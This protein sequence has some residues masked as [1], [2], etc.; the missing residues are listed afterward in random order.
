[1]RRYLPERLEL[2]VLADNSP[3]GDPWYTLGFPQVATCGCLVISEELPSGHHRIG[4]PPAALS[5]APLLPIQGPCVP[6]ALD[7]RPEPLLCE[8]VVRELLEDGLVPETLLA[9]G[10]LND[11]PLSWRKL[12]TPTPL[13][14]DF[15][16]TC[17]AAPLNCLLS[18]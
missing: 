3:G 7:R 18:S 5:A 6:E 13:A 17:R 15:V 16:H 1:M 8:P 9:D 2:K 10:L 11:Q 14:F 4:G 12:R